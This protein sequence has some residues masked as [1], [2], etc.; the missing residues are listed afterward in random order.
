VY[1]NPAADG[2]LRSASTSKPARRKL[3]SVRNRWA[4]GALAGTAMTALSTGAFLSA[5]T[6]VERL[7]I[8]VLS[9]PKNLVSR[10]ASGIVVD[11]IWTGRSADTTEP[12]SN[13]LNERQTV[14]DG[15]TPSWS[16]SKP[17][18]SSP[19][20]SAT[21]EGN[22]SSTP[23]ASSSKPMTGKFPRSQ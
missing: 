9:A 8:A 2:S 10:T 6:T 17:K 15:S 20:L 23:P 11:P 21:T 18:R 3:S 22:H 5:R 16:A 19:A 13:R 4:L 1:S 12:H 14:H 7:T